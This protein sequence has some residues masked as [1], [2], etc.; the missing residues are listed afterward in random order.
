MS[1]T[2]FSY[3]PRQTKEVLRSSAK[4]TFRFIPH[5]RIISSGHLLSSDPQSDLGLRCPHLPETWRIC[6]KTWHICPKTWQGPFTVE[7]GNIAQ[8]ALVGCL[9]RLSVIPFLKYMH[10]ILLS[11][12]LIVDVTRKV[13][14][15]TWEY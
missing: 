15:G 12:H 13:N 3:G 1:K 7:S 14:Y 4:C 9:S 8:P 10:F 6:P 2:F 5:M 11:L